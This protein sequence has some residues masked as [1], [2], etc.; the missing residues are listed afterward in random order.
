MVAMVV[1]MTTTAHTRGMGR[2]S[3]RC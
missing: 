2:M 3:H 1:M